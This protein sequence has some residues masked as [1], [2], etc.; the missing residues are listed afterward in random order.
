MRKNE[1][2]FDNQFNEITRFNLRNN[3]PPECVSNEF[4]SDDNLSDDNNDIGALTKADT[5]PVKKTKGNVNAAKN[6]SSGQDGKTYINYRSNQND[7]IDPIIV[8]GIPSARNNTRNNTRNDHSTHNINQNT[9]LE[10]DHENLIPSHR[11]VQD[12]EINEQNENTALHSDLLLLLSNENTI[13]RNDKIN[14]GNDL[15]NWIHMVEETTVEKCSDNQL[16][17]IAFYF[18]H[19]Q[20]V[21]LDDRFHFEFTSILSKLLQMKNQRNRNDITYLFIQYYLLLNGIPSRSKKQHTLI[22]VFKFLEQIDGP[23]NLEDAKIQ[24]LLFNHATFTADDAISLVTILWSKNQIPISHTLLKGTIERL[25]NENQSVDVIALFLESYGNSCHTPFSLESPQIKHLVQKWG[26]SP[27]QL[28]YIWKMICL[29]VKKSSITPSLLVLMFQ[30]AMDIGNFEIGMNVLEFMEGIKN[31]RKSYTDLLHACLSSTIDKRGTPSS[32]PGSHVNRIKGLMAFEVFKRAPFGIQYLPEY[33]KIV[34]NAVVKSRDY[35][36][37]QEV[38]VY[39]RHLKSG[40]M[41][42]L[43]LLDQGKMGKSDRDKVSIL[44]DDLLSSDD[45]Y[46]LKS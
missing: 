40:K 25:L 43:C 33:R 31:D 6:Y 26:H 21:L 14:I 11:L 19:H 18:L 9:L 3:I 34:L 4:V 45:F 15:L 24:S 44:L 8:H 10:N 38:V 30:K 36:A 22:K 5:V 32:I 17:S 42:T 35:E 13:T 39:L 29:S 16:I 23:H 46:L 20:M 41:K 1:F 28:R 27:E 2:P 12:K 37:F 7:K